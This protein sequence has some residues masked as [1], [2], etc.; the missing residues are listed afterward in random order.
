MKG[1]LGGSKS[2]SGPAGVRACVPV[3]KRAS[4]CSLTSSHYQGFRGGIHENPSS[5]ERCRGE[6][7][8]MVGTKAVDSPFNFIPLRD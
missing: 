2:W 4:V 1:K 8:R 5:Y 7:R 6:V 3:V